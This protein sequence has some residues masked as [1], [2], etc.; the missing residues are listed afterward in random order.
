MEQ[1]V[2]ET[3]E[4]RSVIDTIKDVNQV[5]IFVVLV[6]FGFMMGLKVLADFFPS[7]GLSNGVAVLTDKDSDG[8]STGSSTTYQRSFIA[9]LKDTHVFG[10]SSRLIDLERHHATSLERT[11]AARDELRGRYYGIRSET[12]FVFVGPDGQGHVLFQQDVL[13]NQYDLSRDAKVGPHGTEQTRLSRNLY[14]V[15]T[16]DTNRD[17]FLTFEDEQTLYVSDYDGTNLRPLQ[18]NVVSYQEVSADTLIITQIRGATQHFHEYDVV[19]DTLREVKL[20]EL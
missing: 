20:P 2:P 18:K 17:G 13:V 3:N 7:R 4:T 15:T 9:K 12:N 19:K 16:A 10:I 11:G 8:S 1:S 5:A 14:L 6:V